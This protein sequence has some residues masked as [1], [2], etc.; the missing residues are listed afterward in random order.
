MNPERGHASDVGMSALSERGPSW[1]GGDPTG[2][3][4]VEARWTCDV[5]CEDLR[6][7]WTSRL[8]ARWPHVPAR[9]LERAVGEAWALASFAGVPSL[10]F[11]L[12]AEE[13]AMEVVVWHERQRRILERTWA[14][15]TE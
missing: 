11:P 8:R 14:F 7:P 1:D 13:K 5:G 6:G 4:D 15:V 2:V 10:L 12:L 3:G 9:M